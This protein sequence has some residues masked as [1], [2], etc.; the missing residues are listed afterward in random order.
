MRA[1]SVAVGGQT[2]LSLPNARFVEQCGRIM[3]PNDKSPEFRGLALDA[4]EPPADDGVIQLPEEDV[5]YESLFIYPISRDF[6]DRTRLD[7]GKM[8][9]HYVAYL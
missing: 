7:G 6:E 4:E 3:S 1:G 2:G 5:T 8:A 9:R